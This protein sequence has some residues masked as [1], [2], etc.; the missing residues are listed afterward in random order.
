MIKITGNYIRITGKSL[1]H[2]IVR[3][4][5]NTFIS[6]EYSR[7]GKGISFRY[8]VERLSKGILYISRPGRKKNFDFKVVVDKS[9]Q[10]GKGRHVDIAL[11][12]RQIRKHNKRRYNVLFKAINKI[13]NC[14]END[15]DK[16]LK[17]K[18]GFN[19]TF[20]SNKDN[21][22]ILKIIK[23]LFIMEDIVYWDKEGRAFLYNFLRY[24]AE[25]SSKNRLRSVFKKAVSRNG[26]KPD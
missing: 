8:P 3:K 12:L 23:W 16:I 1:R 26:I 15:V 20:R 11:F 5:V 13:Y 17:S 4:V 2:E 24:A 25:E 10:F 22:R 7:K 6:F 21:E 19:K 9:Y 18:T 14:S